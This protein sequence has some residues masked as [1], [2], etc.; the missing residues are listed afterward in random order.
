MLSYRKRT[1]INYGRNRILN[2]FADLEKNDAVN[3]TVR[4]SIKIKTLKHDSK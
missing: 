2:Q 1:T 4:R 3:H